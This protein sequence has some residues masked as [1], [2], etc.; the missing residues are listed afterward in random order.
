MSTPTSRVTPRRNITI[1]DELWDDV[2]K[3][4]ELRH[5]NVSAEIRRACLALLAEARGSGEMPKARRKRSAA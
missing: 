2:V 5:S 1:P 3:L 4:A